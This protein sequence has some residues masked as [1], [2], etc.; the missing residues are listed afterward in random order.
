MV[1]IL[2]VCFFREI[3]DLISTNISLR[4]SLAIQKTYCTKQQVWVRSGKFEG[5]KV[6][7]VIET[8]DEHRHFC[9]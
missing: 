6:S 5:R 8:F 1:I 2:S 9:A 7:D 3:E 4:E